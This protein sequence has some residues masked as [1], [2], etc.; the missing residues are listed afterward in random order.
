MLEKESD[1]KRVV[2]ILADVREEMK[3]GE[4]V[5]CVDGRLVVSDDMVNDWRK[6]KQVLG[7]DRE[8]FR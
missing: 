1:W 7:G 6:Q 2:R 5:E 8:K 3:I 4:V